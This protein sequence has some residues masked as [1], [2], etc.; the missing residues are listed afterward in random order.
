M[1][2]ATAALPYEHLERTTAGLRAKLRRQVLAADVHAMPRWDTLTVTGPR[3]FTDLR[4]RSW[5]EY[6]ATVESRRPF[7]PTPTGASPDQVPA[8]SE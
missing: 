4:G 5:Y 2:S 3:E 8:E 1:F 6:E 7:D